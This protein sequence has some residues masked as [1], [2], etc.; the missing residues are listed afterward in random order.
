VEGVLA[1]YLK[2]VMGKAADTGAFRAQADGLAAA[3]LERVR[4][5]GA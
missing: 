5:L 2:G 4:A 3:A 1:R